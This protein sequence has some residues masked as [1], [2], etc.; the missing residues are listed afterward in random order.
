MRRWPA[1]PL[2]MARLACPPWSSSPSTVSGENA[3]PAPT[4]ALLRTPSSS[5]PEPAARRPASVRC[6][7]LSCGQASATHQN[8]SCATRCERLNPRRTPT[9]PRAGQAADRDALLGGRQ[10]LKHERQVCVAGCGRAGLGRSHVGLG[11]ATGFRAS[12]VSAVAASA[13]CGRVGRCGG[14]KGSRA[15]ASGL[16]VQYLRAG[17]GAHQE[18]GGG[19]LQV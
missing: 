15:M 5:P 4:T 12:A 11:R 7:A 14:D 8:G 18:G 17:Q 9:P 19:V 16:G 3:R 10:A 2:S 6:D 13:R 1:G